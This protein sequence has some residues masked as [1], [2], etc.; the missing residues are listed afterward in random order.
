MFGG[1]FTIVF[2]LYETYCWQPILRNLLNNQGKQYS[3]G[4]RTYTCEQCEEAVDRAKPS[5]TFWA[6]TEL[7]YFCCL[8]CR[9]KWLDPTI[10][11]SKT[12]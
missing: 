10:L 5:I 12:K 1:K 6:Y 8:L 11:D 3:A 9:D 2:K 7:H 4:S